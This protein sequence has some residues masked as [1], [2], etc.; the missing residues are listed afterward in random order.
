MT[1]RYNCGSKVISVHE[2]V[3]IVAIIRVSSDAV[4]KRAPTG[5]KIRAVDVIGAESKVTGGE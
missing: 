2:V 3:V 4:G 5:M 1:A